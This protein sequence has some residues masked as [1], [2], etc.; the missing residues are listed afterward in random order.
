VDYIEPGATGD[1]ETLER[2]K[3]RATSFSLN[4]GETRTLNLTV[5]SF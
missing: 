1:P 3:A 4:E 5:T 2:L